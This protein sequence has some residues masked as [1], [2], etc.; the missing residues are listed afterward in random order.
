MS[1]GD[2]FAARGRAGSRSPSGGAIS[3]L[4][5]ID[6]AA[7][8]ARRHVD[9]G[10]RHGSALQAG[11]ER[12]DHVGAVGPER[13]VAHLG[14]GDELSA[15]SASRMRVATRARPARGPRWNSGDVR[16]RVLL[17]EDGDASDVI[18]GVIGLSTV[19]VRVTE[20]PFSTSGGMSSLTRPSP[21]RGV[22][23]EVADRRLHRLRPAAPGGA[24]R[25]RRQA[26]GGRERGRGREE[27]ASTGSAAARRFIVSALFPQ[28]REEGDD[29]LD[30]A[31]RSGPACRGRPRATRSRPSVR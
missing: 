31:R 12:H 9:E 30:L 15:R 27:V 7:L 21:D 8:R 17:V 6:L 1:R 25:D 16:L 26:A 23:R 22:A 10:A 4:I 20:L 19:T 28:R 18:G 29:I 5:S 13:A 24:D 11:G 2:R 3:V 14:D